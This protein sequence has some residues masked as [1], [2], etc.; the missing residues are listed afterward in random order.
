[1]TDGRCCQQGEHNPLIKAVQFGRTEVVEAL[2]SKKA[3]V[4]RK[5]KARSRCL[6][7]CRRRSHTSHSLLQGGCT[8][9]IWATRNGSV[10]LVKLL[11]KHGADVTLTDAVRKESKL[12][13]A[14]SG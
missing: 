10:E 7:S 4:D 6:M 9:L 1:M 2:L 8:A 13:C 3:Y 11:L 14:T 5:D 12:C